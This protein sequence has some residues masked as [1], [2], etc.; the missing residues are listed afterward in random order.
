MR[1]KRLDFGLESITRWRVGDEDH[2]P[3]EGKAAPRFQPRHRE[4]DEIL[5]RPSLDE[6]LTDALQPLYIDP[7]LL[8][9]SVL[10]A[11]RQSTR[12]LLAAAAESASGHRQAVL[13]DAAML[14]AE[15]VYLDQEVQAA[16]A[17]LLKG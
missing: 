17:A 9:P 4:L 7:D 6:R 5:R 16:I 14:L 8:E 15:D 12:Q 3:V 11:T 2:L 1:A 10:S 13:A